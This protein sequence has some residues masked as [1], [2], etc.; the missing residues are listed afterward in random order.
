[1]RILY[2]LFVSCN[3]LDGSIPFVSL[4]FY[5]FCQGILLLLMSKILIARRSHHACGCNQSDWWNANRVYQS[6]KA[7]RNSVSG[8]SPSPSFIYSLF[9]SGR[10]VVLVEPV[11]YQFLPVQKVRSRQRKEKARRT[12]WRSVSP[13]SRQSIIVKIWHASNKKTDDWWRE[14][15]KY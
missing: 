8:G 7:P 15:G 4:S 3:F 6:L 9:N 12:W 14:C 11:K 5:P 10:L 1:M 2:L 13:A